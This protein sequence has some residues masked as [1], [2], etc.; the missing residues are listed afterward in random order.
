MVQ[1]A[2]EGWSYPF[3]HRLVRRTEPL[4]SGLYVSWRGKT[5]GGR[6]GEAESIMSARS[7]LSPTTDIDTETSSGSG[8]RTHDRPARGEGVLQSCVL[9]C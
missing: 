3:R 2:M 4:S 5:S 1:P 7:C 6:E 9:D 8:Q